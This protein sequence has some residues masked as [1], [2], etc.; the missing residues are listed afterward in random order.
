MSIVERAVDMLGS[1]AQSQRKPA[2]E[3]G[4]EFPGPG[5]I[6]RVAAHE[7]QRADIRPDRNSI[8]EE[9][10]AP[11]HARTA[12][13]ISRRLKI[14]L[15]RLRQQSMITPDAERT[16]ISENFRR[17]KRHL[18][19]NV[20]N[21][22]A[23]PGANRIMIT[24]ALPNEGKTFCAINLAISI[25]ME[26]DRTVLL[27]D[28]DV[29][30]PSVTAVLGIQVEAEKGLMDVLLHQTELADVMCKTDIN[31]L[32]ILPAGTRHGHATEVLAS[33]AMRELL[34]EMT[35]RYAD[36]IIIFDSPP[37]LTASEACVLASC[38]GQILVVV[39]AG[40]TTESA[41]K[42]ALSRIESSNVVGV[43]LNKGSPPGAGYYGG[44]GDGYGESV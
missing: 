23:V 36:R 2:V 14:D 10:I 16:P 22:E 1:S 17:I 8:A 20:A 39:E 41:L 25:A 3:K 38:M 33:E 40:K 12:R 9:I 30:R 5:L 15:G 21:L 37:L 24:S 13:R 35:D 43:L 26:T 11:E 32:S 44:Y 42:D 6:E 29:A 18:L 31:K 7:E 19:A 4:Q 27:V 28:A 34:L